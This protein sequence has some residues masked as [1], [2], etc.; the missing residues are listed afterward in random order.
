[1]TSYLN[2][3]RNFIDITTKDGQ[4]LLS[5]A[6]DKFE[7]PLIGD[8]KISLRPGGKDFQKLKDELT[9]LSQRY[10]Y[11]YLLQNVPTVRTVI[12]AIPPVIEDLALGIAA[13][14]GVP[15]AITYTNEI[16]MLEVYSDKLLEIS[17]KN[18]SMTWGNES[19]TV[20]TPRVIRE[21]T[22]ANGELTAT[23]KKLTA[24]GKEAIQKR[25]HSKIFAFQVMAMLSNDARKVIERQYEEY[26]WYDRTGPDEEM[27][28]QIIVALILKRL[29]PHYK[30]DMYSEIGTIK[31]M[32]VAQY[33][34]DINLFCDSI[35]SVKLQIDSKD[36]NAYTDEAFVRDIFV[37]I[38]NEML[39]HDFKSEFTSL[40][41]RWQ[42]D[43]EIVTSQSLMDDASTYY[44]N[45]V[46]SGDWKSEVS[47]HSQIIALT[48]QITELKKEFNEVKAAKNIIPTP[49]GS[50][51]TGP[52]YNKF[53]Q[54]RLEKVD[55][56]E[57]FNMVVRDGKTYCWCD[58]HKFPSSNVQGM[59]VFHKPTEHDVWQE[60]KSALNGRRGGKKGEKEKAKTP[61]STPPVPKPSSTPSAAKLSLAKSLQEALATTT[62][63]SDDQFT[64][65]WDKCCSAS[66]N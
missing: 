30:V 9:R 23:T 61:A 28:G 54:W 66:G 41:R 14:P 2:A 47:K 32:T 62:G 31:K 64:K 35:K 4:A 55:N 50:T 26:T 57:E 20:Q 58:K 56:K 49:S 12:P 8:N 6:T 52:G 60:R 65:I 53:E 21:L 1:M 29:R 63:L 59:Y 48:T 45:M 42:M 7:S 25:I 43:K 37:Q 18:S 44:T 36:P 10:G 24:T 11:Q 5:N 39:P 16:N 33:D 40:E 46:A 34:N 38:K 22:Q 17:Q 19:F 3:Y 13:A 27:D 51:P 15:E